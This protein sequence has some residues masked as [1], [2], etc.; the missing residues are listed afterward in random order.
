MTDVYSDIDINFGTNVKTKDLN[1]NSNINAIKNSIR[2]ILQTRK[3]E[4]RMLPE[5]GASLEQLLFE[6]IDESTAKK[7]GTL[8]IE[9]VE[10]WDPRVHIEN[11]DVIADEDNFRYDINMMYSIRLSTNSNNDVISF[12]LQ[13]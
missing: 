1:K 3:M 2:N 13:G 7:I 5:F 9:E 10:F 4:R 12:V 11:I 6:P 8:M